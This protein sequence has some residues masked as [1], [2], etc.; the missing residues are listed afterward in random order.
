MQTRSLHSVAQIAIAAALVAAVSGCCQG[1]QQPKAAHTVDQYLAKP[2]LMEAKLRECANNPGE[3]RDN[4][5]CI[6]VNAATVKAAAQKYG[7]GSMK[8]MG[9][10]NASPPQG[11]NGSGQP[12][13]SKQ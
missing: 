4:P 3:L 10:L 7:T 13:E 9:P 8:P 1:T 6:N 5:D 12:A 11:M 2:D